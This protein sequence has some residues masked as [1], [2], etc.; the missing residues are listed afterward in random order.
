[1]TFDAKFVYQDI[2][3]GV[4]GDWQSPV[5]TCAV[6]SDRSDRARFGQHVPADRGT[7]IG[8]RLAAR[9]RARAPV[10][11]RCAVLLPLL[12]LMPPAFVFVGIIWRDVL[13]GVTLA[14]RRRR[15]PSRRAERDRA[16]TRMPRKRG[17][18]AVRLRRAAASECADRCADPCGLH[19]L[20]GADFLAAHRASL[21][22]G[23]GR[24]LRPGAGRLLRRARTRRGSIRCS[25]SWCSISAASAISPRRT[26]SGDLE[27]AGNGD[28]CSTAAT[29]RPSGTFIG[30]SSLAIS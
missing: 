27:R 6:D 9:L 28:C 16:S 17:A 13:F 24:V 4:L 7:R 11:A 26:S 15:S 19:R 2:A 29:S 8:W 20:A 3:K 23:D 5:M 25:R 10:N 14:A 21:C 12:A 30:G 1:M 22:P 18:R